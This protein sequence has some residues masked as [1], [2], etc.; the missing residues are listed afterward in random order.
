MAGNFGERQSEKR[1][2]Q[3]TA[4]GLMI[5]ED[6]RKRADGN[7]KPQMK[8]LVGKVEN[9]NALINLKQ[10]WKPIEETA[11]IGDYGDSKIEEEWEKSSSEPIEEGEI[12]VTNDE[13]EVRQPYQHR[14][15]GQSV[16]IRN[17]SVP[18]VEGG[19]VSI[20]NDGGSKACGPVKWAIRRNRYNLV[21]AHRKYQ[22]PPVCSRP[23]KRSWKEI[24]EDPFDL[25]CFLDLGILGQQVEFGLDS[26]KVAEQ[27]SNKCEGFHLNTRAD[28]VEASQD[29][30]DEDGSS[31]S[32]GC[33]EGDSAPVK[34][35]TSKPG[36]EVEETISIGAVV[37]GGEMEL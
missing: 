23:K 18:P 29:P 20:I 32:V 25:D 17:K 22:A 1:Y 4:T 21:K 6:N 30:V 3:A 33:S 19:E 16:T 2:R 28:S 8:A 10:I 9:L 31:E 35:D 26:D 15:E 37:P 13:E 7:S 11:T 27:I 24:E 34:E 5:E 36:T 14:E 12:L